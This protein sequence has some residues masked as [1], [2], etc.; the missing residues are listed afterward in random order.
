MAHSLWI[1][2]SSW[3]AN[4]LAFIAA[5]ERPSLA[6]SLIFSA[7]SRVD[8]PSFWP[9]EPSTFD[10]SSE[11]KRKKKRHFSKNYTL[12][13]SILPDNG[14]LITHQQLKNATTITHHFSDLNLQ[15]L[16]HGHHLYY[17]RFLNLSFIYASKKS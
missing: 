9:H 14:D 8:P 1:S 17:A 15:P 13:I 10:L 11:F 2:R 3:S 4:N 5:A 12:G 16:H 6:A 7:D